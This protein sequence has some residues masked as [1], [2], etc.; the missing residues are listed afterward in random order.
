MF[1]SFRVLDNVVIIG[2]LCRATI[3]L[4]FLFLFKVTEVKIELRL[5]NLFIAANVIV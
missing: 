4:V 3:T 1:L 5:Y 2:E